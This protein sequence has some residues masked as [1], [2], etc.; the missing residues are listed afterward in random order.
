[1]KYK[2]N[3][4]GFRFCAK[5]RHGPPTSGFFVV[6][7]I[8]F[9]PKKEKMA[10]FSTLEQRRIFQIDWQRWLYPLSSQKV[11]LG[12]QISARHSRLGIFKTSIFKR[13]VD[14]NLILKTLLT[15]RNSYDEFFLRISDDQVW[16]FIIL[17]QQV[18]AVV[19][20]IKFPYLRQFH[21]KFM[22][23]RR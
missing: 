7:Y 21:E 14:P 19:S 23:F 8:Y 12:L 6:L 13:K 11:L 15:I 3:L 17:L 4:Q 16:S 22:K 20:K 1:M 10:S 18:F 2:K 9:D 5:N